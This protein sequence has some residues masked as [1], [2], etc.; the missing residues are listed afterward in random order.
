MLV[1][2]SSG[3]LLVDKAFDFTGRGKA[4]LNNTMD[5]MDEIA[6][7][8]AIVSRLAVCGAAL[9]MAPSQAGP[10][11]AY[12]LTAPE[13]AV[14]N[15]A[16]NERAAKFYLGLKR[17]TLDIS[18]SGSFYVRRDKQVNAD[19]LSYVSKS[20]GDVIFDIPLS[21][22]AKSPDY[23]I[24]DANGFVYYSPQFVNENK[25]M[26]QAMFNADKLKQAEQSNRTGF[27]AAY[28]F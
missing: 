10:A 13:L 12:S 5:K 22:D 14:N 1:F 3:Q 27:V 9:G 28:K 23:M 26:F 18:A 25:A 24:S 2:S 11:L 7:T 19:F 20:T 8:V 4:R 16:R 6:S 21:E 17:M 15:L